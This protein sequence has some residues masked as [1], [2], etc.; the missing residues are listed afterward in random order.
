[1]LWEPPRYLYDLR[2]PAHGISGQQLVPY[3]LRHKYTVRTRGL[4]QQ[5]PC[6]D[7]N[8]QSVD[9]TDPNCAGGPCGAAAAPPPVPTPQPNVVGAAA[10]TGAVLQ[11][12]GTWEVVH[13]TGWKIAGQWLPTSPADIISQVSYNLPGLQVINQSNDAGFSQTWVQGAP[14]HVTLVLQV[15]GPGFASPNDAKSIVDHAYY[16]VMGGMP[17]TSSINV[18]SLPGGGQIA[19]P[20]PPG[21][22]PLAPITTASSMTSWFQQNTGTFILLAIALVALPPLIKKL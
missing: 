21:Q 2:G 9:C 7:A 13:S 5:A 1:M 6:Y 16:T 10:P 8:G 12:Q 17:I 14:F 4:G 15:T 3:G 11:Y 19:V 22:Q 20:L 18:S